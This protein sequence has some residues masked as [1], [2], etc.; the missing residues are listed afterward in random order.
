MEEPELDYEIHNR[1]REEGKPFSYTIFEYM[2]V[3]KTILN[4]QRNI[5]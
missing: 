1:K 2:R 4:C 3:N 5:I